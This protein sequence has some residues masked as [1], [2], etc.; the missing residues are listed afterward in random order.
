MLES[1]WGQTR[2]QSGV[3]APLS[4][5]PPLYLFSVPHIAFPSVCPQV[6]VVLSELGRQVRALRGASL[7]HPFSGMNLKW[8]LDDFL[9]SMPVLD[10]CEVF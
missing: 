4:A 8:H 10:L 2:G 7:Q 6:F 9:V 3:K 5:E 1:S